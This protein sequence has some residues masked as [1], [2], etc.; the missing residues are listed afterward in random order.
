MTMTS[1]PLTLA[2]T[3]QRK[4]KNEKKRKNTKNLPDRV[5]PFLRDT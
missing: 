4:K 3:F 2:R 5:H 1:D